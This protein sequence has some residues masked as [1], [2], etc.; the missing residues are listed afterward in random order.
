MS[1]DHFHALV[2]ES[3]ASTTMHFITFKVTNFEKTDAIEDYLIKKISTLDRFLVSIPMPHEA[4]V[5]VG[6]ETRHRKKGP[7]F[8]C[9]INLR[10]PKHLLR[11]ESSAESLYAAIDLTVAE[12]KRQIVKFKE[13]PVA[14]RKR[15]EKNV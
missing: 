6:K 11:A 5:E 12:L 4:H 1:S 13:R 2:H 7:Y 14:V 3:A 9:E 10:L 15:Q 8:R